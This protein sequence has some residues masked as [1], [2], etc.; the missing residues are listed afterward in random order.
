V[1]CRNLS[2]VEVEAHVE[3]SDDRA[4]GWGDLSKSFL[5]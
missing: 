5:R 2:C 1:T 4:L 3:E